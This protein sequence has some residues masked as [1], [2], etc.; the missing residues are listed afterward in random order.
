MKNILSQL[1]YNNKFRIFLLFLILSFGSLI[2]NKLSK[3][4]KTTLQFEVA[5][6]NIPSNKILL[7]TENSSIRIYVTATGYNLIGYKLINKKIKISADN[8]KRIRNTTHAINS[9]ILIDEIQQQLLI[10]TEIIEIL[11]PTIAIELGEIITKKVPIILK[12]SLTY[13]KGYKIKGEVSID[14]DSITISGPEDKVNLIQ[15]VES[16]LLTKDKIYT[17]INEDVLLNLKSIP[18]SVKVSTTQFKVYADVEKFTELVFK[19]PFKVI[20][21]P[22]SLNVETFPSQ[23]EV[24]FQLE[25]SEI[26]KVSASNFEVIGDLAYSQENKLSYL[27]PKISKKP[28]TIQNIYVKPLKIDFI[29]RK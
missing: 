25:L 19:V 18:E 14:P 11:N 10:G 3:E 7:K 1:F 21:N 5:I 2:L 16:R 8:A 13:E 20:N 23:V 4:Y 24:V 9:S 22:T 28:S 27:V 12:K 26:S 29:I 17:T 15:F 6:S